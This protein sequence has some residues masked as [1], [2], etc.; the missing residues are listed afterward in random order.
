MKPSVGLVV[1]ELS[2]VTRVVRRL[3]QVDFLEPRWLCRIVAIE[4]HQALV[5]SAS[6]EVHSIYAGAG[7]ADEFVDDG[8]RAIRG[9]LREDRYRSTGL[10]DYVSYARALTI[11][12]TDAQ[13]RIVQM[14]AEIDKLTKAADV[15]YPRM[16]D[17]TLW[18]MDHPRSPL[19]GAGNLPPLGTML[20]RAGR[21][22]GWSGSYSSN[23]G[24]LRSE[25]RTWTAEDVDTAFLKAGY[26]VVGYPEEEDAERVAFLLQAPDGTR[27]WEWD[28]NRRSGRA[29]RT[30]AEVEAMISASRADRQ[31]EI[32]HERLRLERELAS[33]E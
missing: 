8:G 9:S 31:T 3:E 16:A 33:L 25:P 28:Y 17:D 7:L 11:L 15:T 10:S 21:D 13:A 26:V 32:V 5:E 2:H 4:S 23:D 30:R 22:G 12:R 27:R 6:G 24:L 1:V 19:R 18:H 20:V 29:Y 14:Q